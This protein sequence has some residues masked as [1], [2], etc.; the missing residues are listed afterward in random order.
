MRLAQQELERSG[1]RDDITALAKQ[2]LA[3]A[4]SLAQPFRNGVAALVDDVASEIEGRM[5]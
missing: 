5:P 1:A 4:R 3:H 2:H